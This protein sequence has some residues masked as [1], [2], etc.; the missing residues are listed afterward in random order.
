[1]NCAHARDEWKDCEKSGHHECYKTVCLKCGIVTYR[2]CDPQTSAL[3]L[4]DY[5]VE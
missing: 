4:Y 1:V 5:E 3:L 2:D